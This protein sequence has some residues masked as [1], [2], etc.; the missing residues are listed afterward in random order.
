[1]S[2]RVASALPRRRPPGRERGFAL[3]LI[4]SLVVLL[5][6]YLLVNALNRSSSQLSNAREERTQGA[7]LKAK[8]ALIAYAAS[9]QWQAYKGQST[10]Q[11]GAL[12]C[13]D[14]DDDGDADCIGP[15]ITNSVS[16]IGRLPWKTL[17]TDDLRDASGERLWYA[18]SRNYR[19]L[20]GV[21]VVNSD[22]QGQLGVIGTTTASNVVAIVVAPGQ[23]V[24]G[25]DRTAGHNSPASYLEGFN[26]NDNINYVFTTN[27]IPSD[28][29]NDR[30]VAI[31]QADLMAAV[32]PV[33]SARI[34]RDVKPYLLSYFNQWGAFPFPARFDNPNPGSSGPG[35]TRAQVT[36]AGDPTQAAGLLPLTDLSTT[37]NPYP[38][39]AG[40]GS[41]TKA[42]GTGKVEFDSC[43]SVA[44]PAGTIP[45]TGWRC[46]FKARDDGGF[47][48]IL[49]L[50]VQISGQVG[51][52]AGASFAN[53]PSTSAVT[54]TIDGAAATLLSPTIRGSLTNTGRGTV[55]YEATLPILCFN[56]DHDVEVIIPD[57]T[58]GGPT[59]GADVNITAATN[60]SPI[61][62][63]TA[64]AHKL[65]TGL[66]VTIS[67][68]AGNTAANGSWSVTVTDATHF[69]LNGSSGNGNYSGG[70]KAC[71]AA[72]WFVA[73]EWYRQTY[74]AVSPGYLPGGGG[75]CVARPSPPAAALAPSC[76]MV[77]NLSP[78]Y[79]VA[80]DK[81]AILILAGR[82]LN[83]SARPSA[84]TSD[85]LEGAN[86]TLVATPYIFENR[87]GVPTSI[88]DRVVVVSP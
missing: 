57:I 67:N 18:V 12:P 20:S 37:P 4:L 74:Y 6:S 43:A 41:A 60:T 51:T 50:R 25:Q 34:E 81:Q 65:A 80:N 84:Q 52:D 85:Y 68:A 86:A 1:V 7:L 62:I 64:S 32:E 35:T 42:G 38:W 71:S 44:M 3:I 54:A 5:S 16:L 55:M 79:A 17:G 28:A 61:S 88:N 47:N 8:S 19:K 10:N 59:V 72:C 30:L 40:S 77:N 87:P 14:Q 36:Y 11:P 70:G 26:A 15:G 56:C 33:V 2:R 76:L 82:S 9:E 24:Q 13:P 73:N 45:S 31:T 46:K 21:T 66:G 53:L 75:G 48:I 58:V 49:N 39:S 22:A 69:T 83:G 78:A 27:A 29:L 63:T 23:V